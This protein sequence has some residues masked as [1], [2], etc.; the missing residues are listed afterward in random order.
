LSVKL[1]AEIGYPAPISAGRVAKAN[2]D[3]FQISGP[4]VL[5]G[6][7]GLAAQFDQHHAAA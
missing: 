5:G 6:T 4:S 2:A 7:G 1:V 3:V